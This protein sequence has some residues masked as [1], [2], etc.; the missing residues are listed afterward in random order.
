MSKNNSS[1]HLLNVNNFNVMISRIITFGEAFQPSRESLTVQGLQS[2]LKKSEDTLAS[3]SAAEVN[4]MNIIAAR[5][6]AFQPLD[7]LVTRSNQRFT[8]HRRIAGNPRA[9][10]I[11]GQGTQG[12][13]GFS[14]SG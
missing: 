3:V 12:H 7:S 14:H 1:G 5:Q 13:K 6:N 9:G 10:R 2:L 11:H 8:H 4:E